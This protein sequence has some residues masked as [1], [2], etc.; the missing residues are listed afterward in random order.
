V[1]DIRTS[2]L[3]DVFQDSIRANYDYEYGIQDQDALTGVKAVLDSLNIEYEDDAAAL[4][5][6]QR[7]ERVARWK[8][9]EEAMLAAMT[10]EQRK[11]YE[12]SKCGFL[13][14]I[15]E[16]IVQNSFLEKKFKDD[17]NAR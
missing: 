8:A 9:E 7:L 15:V 1:S 11:V 17:L 10:P 6:R 2:D 16:I 5:E 4:W 14:N 12:A 3:V 13:P